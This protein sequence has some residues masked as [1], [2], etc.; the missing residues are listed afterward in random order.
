IDQVWDYALDLKYFHDASHE[1]CILPALTATAA[2][3]QIFSITPTVHNDGLTQPICASPSQLSELCYTSLAYFHA[4]PTDATAWE[5]GRYMPT[6]TIVEAA[7][8]LYA[9]HAVEEISR[10]GAGTRNLTDTARAI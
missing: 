7:R 2:P 9:G 4:P 6:P 5:R 10:S 8:A 3:K 1:L